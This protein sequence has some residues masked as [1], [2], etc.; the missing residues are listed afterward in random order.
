MTKDSNKNRKKNEE[1]AP[2]EPGQPHPMNSDLFELSNTPAVEAEAVQELINSKKKTETSAVR[3]LLA[4]TSPVVQSTD[5][6]VELARALRNDPQLIFQWVYQNIEYSPMNGVQKGV[7]CVIDGNGTGFDQSALLVALLREAAL[8]NTDILE[9]NFVYGKIQLTF[10]Q[11]QDWLG[12]QDSIYL[13]RDLLTNGGFYATIID[14]FGTPLLEVDHCWVQLK[15]TGNVTYVLDPSF[16]SYERT[17]GLS[18]SELQQWM[19]YS[20]AESFIASAS[21]GATIDPGGT[22]VQ[23]LNTS[24]VY[25]QLNLLSTNLIAA[26]KKHDSDWTCSLSGAITAGDVITLTVFNAGLV[27]G[28]SAASYTIQEGDT[29]LADVA[30]GLAAAINASGTITGVG[31]SAVPSGAVITLSNAESTSYISSLSTEATI[32]VATIPNQPA[33]LDTII[34]G[35]KIIPI[36]V[37]FTYLSALP[38][39]KPG[40]S[41]EIWTA[42]TGD[43]PDDYRVRIELNGA[44]FGF[45]PGGSFILKY[46]DELYGKRLTIFFDDQNPDHTQNTPRLLQDGSVIAVGTP[47]DVDAPECIMFIRVVHNAYP[48]S[49]QAQ[50]F[51]LNMSAKAGQLPNQNTLYYLIGIN[52]GVAGKG[53]VDFHQHR[54]SLNEYDAGPGGDL[55][56]PVLGEQLAVQW[57]TYMAELSVVRERIGQMTNNV[58][59]N[60]H[61]MGMS[62]YQDGKSYQGVY[63][64]GFFLSVPGTRYSMSSLDL[65]TS[66]NRNSYKVASMV[67][68]IHGYGLEMLAIQQ[69]TGFEAATIN[70]VLSVSNSSAMKIYKADSTN[71]STIREELSGYTDADLSSIA[72]ALNTSGTAV[73]IPKSAPLVLES[74]S[75][76][77][78]AYLNSNLGVAGGRHWQVKGGGNTETV[79]LKSKKTKN[80]CDSKVFDPVNVRTGDFTYQHEDLC[81]GSGTFPY[82]LT[83]DSLYN[84]RFRLE[85]NSMGLGWTHNWMYSATIASDGFESLGIN[86]PIS[87]AASIVQWYVLLDLI[88]SDAALPIELVLTVNECHSWW[89]EQSTENVV[90]VRFPN[91]DY[92]FSLL[93]DGSYSAPFDADLDLT[94]SDGHYQVTSDVRTRYLFSTDGQLLEIALPYGV[95]ITLTYDE[96]S[97]LHSVANGFSRTLTCHYTNELLTSVSDNTGREV[98][99]DFDSSKQRI[100]FSDA[101]SSVYKFEYDEPGRLEKLFSPEH[102][103]VPVITNTYNSLD[104]ISVQADAYGNQTKFYFAGTRTETVDPLNQKT[105]FYL[106]GL[107]NVATQIDS[108]GHIIS[109][110]FDPR[111]RRIRRTMPEGNVVEYVYDTSRNWIQQIAKPKPVSNLEPTIMVAT[112]DPICGRIKTSQDRN[113]NVTSYTYDDTEGNFGNLLTIESPAVD[114]EIGIIS[115]TYDRG[116]LL[117]RTDETGIVTRYFYNE[118]DETIASIVIDF[119]EDQNHLNLTTSFSYNLYGDISA[120]TDPNSNTSSFEY[121]DLRTLIRITEP[122]PF[123]LVTHLSYDKN[124]NLIE[125]KRSNEDISQ[126]WSFTYSLNDI[127]LSSIDP[128]LNAL[129]Y[130]YDAVNQQRTI[131]NAE[132]REWHFSY[133]TEGRLTEVKSPSNEIVTCT[134]TA[135]GKVA[136]VTDHRNKTTFYEYD[137]LDR[138]QK[139]TFADDS[140]EQVWRDNNGNVV[141]FQ[142]RAGSSFK[143]EFTHDHRNRLKSKSPLNQPEI[144]YVYDLAGRLVEM[145][146]SGGGDPSFGSICFGFDTAGRTISETYPDGKVIEHR[147]DRNGNVI[148]CIWPDLYYVT[149][150]YDALNRLTDIH[151]NG[152]SLPSAHFSYNA[153]SQKIR[154]DFG[155]GTSIEYTPQPNGDITQISHNFDGAAVVFSYNYNQ[156]HQLLSV[157]VSDSS[158]LWTPNASTMTTYG[159]ADDVNKY[160]EPYDYDLNANQTLAGLLTCSYDSENRLNTAFNSNTNIEASFSYDACGRQTQKVVNTNNKT[161]YLYAGWQRYADYDGTTDEISFRYIYGDNLDDIVLIISS[162]NEISYVHKDR[163]GSVVALS[164]E[165]GVLAQKNAFGPFGEVNSST[166]SSFGFTAQRYDSEIDLHYFKNRMYYAALGRFL[167][168]DP[169]GYTASDLNLYNYVANDPINQ[170][171]PL[172]LRPLWKVERDFIKK[173]FPDCFTD[174]ELNDWHLNDKWAPFRA[175]SPGNGMIW[176]D[177]PFNSDDI[178]SQPRLAHEVFHVVQASEN[179]TF[180]AQAAVQQYHYYI[181]DG[182]S[183]AGFLP[184]FPKYDPYLY[185]KKGDALD[186][187]RNGNVERQAQM[188]QDAILDALKNP[189][190]KPSSWYK[191]ILD[192]VAK[193]CC[194]KRAKK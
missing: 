169:V 113:G 156:T 170:I 33:D 116:R 138:H 27:G 101:S 56:E 62:A 150:I 39:E 133:D 179:W 162:E 21:Q 163:I 97:R 132:N 48:G 98:Q 57:A 10:A 121:D 145:T 176:L 12:I 126:I 88:G 72:Q 1:K 77:A 157:L 193:K 182:R 9:A 107:G 108:Q 23:D 136:T 36:D 114:N 171:D 52:I 30:I 177:T 118:S 5:T 89:V 158:F 186:Q 100:T 183:P 164:D 92:S 6:V 166:G 49:Q 194:E 139:T 159:S 84:S 35:K 94:L 96:D 140:F 20:D 42:A 83:F 104:M 25:S 167:Q 76:R 71:W 105:I 15:L 74:M 189:N 65:D 79:N 129:H 127:I 148:M 24:N 26:I 125:V 168:T 117:T 63:F 165:N 22:W 93:P 144:G 70:K 38:Y 175:F 131:K 40:D 141:T 151:L 154:T 135:N 78:W 90:E 50:N 111:K 86:S 82:A 191:P 119:G 110:Q 143:I 160:P 137:G 103:N 80:P 161:R 181:A 69:Y 37:P 3:S 109:D 122:V 64:S 60:H 184:A 124:K 180:I 112:F 53:I 190:G 187:F 185:D 61:W 2:F 95:V 75:C 153:L 19:G 59:Q 43:I 7:A 192:E 4:A 87:G 102:P 123:D 85:N 31:V 99:Y 54:L 66:Y 73:F 134:Y 155:N 46:A 55:S 142:P 17:N 51:A 67:H 58:I 91:R 120:I 147:L 172:G 178:N 44:A 128:G 152:D 106:D 45:N 130:S 11:C 16:K 18:D 41:P 32:A 34:G 188:V 173:W 28:K 146:K 8:K 68:G 47:Q 174:T 13:A 115:L 149:R 14:P 81:I 29:T